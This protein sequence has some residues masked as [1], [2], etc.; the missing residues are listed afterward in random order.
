MAPA[1]SPPAKASISRSYLR[2]S[3]EG[4][5]EVHGGVWIAEPSRR[6]LKSSRRSEGNQ[7]IAEIAKA[8]EIA[9]ALSN[10]ERWAEIESFD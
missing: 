7:P 2:G 6:A 4:V 9:Q 5:G 1:G 8:S 3:K 10:D